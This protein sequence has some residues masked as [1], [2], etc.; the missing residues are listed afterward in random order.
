MSNFFPTRIIDVSVQ[1]PTLV[2]R[3]SVFE[4]YVALSHQWGGSEL[5]R[6]TLAN[7]QQRRSSIS[8]QE[9]S[10]NIQDAVSIVRGLGFRYLWIDVMGIIQDSEDDWLAESAKMADVF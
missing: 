8:W 4:P 9:L 2:E 7:I 3:I 5:P 6:T 10:K 1:E